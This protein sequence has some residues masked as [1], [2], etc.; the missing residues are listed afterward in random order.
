VEKDV[1]KVLK[2]YSNTVSQRAPLAIDKLR[3]SI[4]ECHRS[5]IWKQP[6]RYLQVATDLRS[7]LTEFFNHLPN[8]HKEE[9]RQAQSYL[10]GRLSFLQAKLQT[11]DHMAS[12][13]LARL[14]I[15]MGILQGL[16]ELDLAE[17]RR[18][19]ELDQKRSGND[20]RKWIEGQRS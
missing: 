1:E 2:G 10:D 6:L 5:I 4:I 12:I 15:Q 16:L 3:K 13:S 8:E 7:I 20:E 19:Q 18:Q 14:Q 17:Q 11:L 9:L